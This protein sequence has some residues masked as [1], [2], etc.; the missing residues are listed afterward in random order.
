MPSPRALRA[1]TDDFNS[2]MPDAGSVH[3]LSVRSRSDRGRDVQQRPQQEPRDSR[4]ESQPEGEPQ[5]EDYG[6]LQGLDEELTVPD[7]IPRYIN[8]TDEMEGE[9]DH[10]PWAADDED[11]RVGNAI[12]NP[13]SI[14]MGYE[15]TCE[16]RRCR[17]PTRRRCDHC[18]RI[19]CH[20][21]TCHCG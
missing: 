15:P 10:I 3:S 11:R 2:N 14:R 9:P 6:F 8:P 19:V 7:P 13:R 1:A 17:R 16:N 5:N 18:D 12:N 21:C 20:R 4:N